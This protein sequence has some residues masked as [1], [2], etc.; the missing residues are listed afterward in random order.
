[1]EDI[2]E[3]KQILA[4]TFSLNGYPV[5]ILF[6]S[7]ATHN[8][9]SKACTKK[10]QLTIQC[11]NTPYMISTPRGKI[12]TK[13]I[14]MHTPLNLAG[15]VYKLILIVLDG[16][17]IDVILEMGWMKAHNALLDIATHTVYLDSLVHGIATLWMP[18]PS[19]ATPLVHHTTT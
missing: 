4:G 16:Q 11:T 7:S 5:I 19:V 12:V 10:C 18:S 9:I 6:D 2:P 1:M 14:F 8:F 13:Q 15:K 3:G 17:G